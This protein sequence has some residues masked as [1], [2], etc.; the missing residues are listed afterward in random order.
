MEKICERY[1]NLCTIGF[2]WDR[3]D[4]LNLKES[5]F[6][7]GPEIAKKLLSKGVWL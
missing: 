4:L 3:E 2:V 5:P 1:K 7:R 6:D